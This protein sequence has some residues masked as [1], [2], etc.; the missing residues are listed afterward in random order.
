MIEREIDLQIVNF[1]TS[2][3]VARLIPQLQQDLSTSGFDGGKCRI[4]IRD[5]ASEDMDALG[6]GSING[7][8][9]IFIQKGEQNVGF[10]VGHNLLE[11]GFRDGGAPILFILNPDLEIIEPN[12][13]SRLV[14]TLNSSM[15]IFAVGPQLLNTEGKIR[16]WDHGEAGPVYEMIHTISGSEYYRNR[17]EVS[18]VSWVSGAVMG[19]SR[20][21]YENL[22][23]FDPNF[24]LYQEEIDLCLRARQESGRI[25]Y[26][27]SI[28]VIHEGSVVA[29]KK[30]HHWE[31]IQ[32]YVWKHFK[33]KAHYP[34]LKRVYRIDDKKFDRMTTTPNIMSIENQETEK[35]PIKVYAPELHF[36]D[37]RDESS[38]PTVPIT[39][40]RSRTQRV[41][42]GRQRFFPGSD[43]FRSEMRED[44]KNKEVELH[45][46]SRFSVKIEDLKKTVEGGAEGLNRGLFGAIILGYDEKLDREVA[47]KVVHSGLPHD[48]LTAESVKSLYKEARFFG[49]LGHPN[50]LKVHDVTVFK[51]EDGTLLPAMIV[52]KAEGSLTEVITDV[53]ERDM[54]SVLEQS[55]QIAKDVGSAADYLHEQGIIHRDIKPENIL[56]V[57]N[58]DGEKYVLAD[59]GLI[60]GTYRPEGENDTLFNAGTTYYGAPEQHIGVL[61]DLGGRIGVSE[62]AKHLPQ[63][64]QYSLAA[65]LL[66]VI[67]GDEASEFKPFIDANG[68]RHAHQSDAGMNIK[69]YGVPP[70][71]Y[72]VLKKAMSYDSSDRYSS[73]KEFADAFEKAVESLKAQ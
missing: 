30:D 1:D 60:Q 6:I 41:L 11:E 22:G 61:Q 24:F 45:E 37:K 71:V 69:N 67:S 57:K 31:S 39:D 20:V 56:L 32:Y 5:N 48:S 55:V 36:V 34:V 42:G 46:G 44:Y 15:D 12:T 43:H 47:F 9:N 23:G 68:Q 52:E 38:E 19:V 58:E 64:D 73:C 17:S 28:K 13:I 16:R 49:N 4:I 40:N 25:V 50:L 29:R 10:G 27:P 63:T 65:T 59:F 66:K 33:D 72:D 2:A 14:E 53:K 35:P 51:L 54:L 70:Q 18:D 21:G 3:H 62:H 7:A 8:K 26:N